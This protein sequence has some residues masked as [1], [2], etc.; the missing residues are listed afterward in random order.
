MSHTEGE[1]TKEEEMQEERTTQ[2]EEEEEAARV[3]EEE[4]ATEEGRDLADERKLEDE[5]KRERDGCQT[6]RSREAHEALNRRH[7]EAIFQLEFSFRRDRVD[8]GWTC[9]TK[10]HLPRG[11]CFHNAPTLFQM[12]TLSNMW[13][14]TGD[15]NSHGRA[16]CAT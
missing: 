7:R 9:A 3:S 10:G 4:L 16:T 8:V 13:K 1:E 14:E 12:L 5:E 11:G 2:E 15:W 6:V